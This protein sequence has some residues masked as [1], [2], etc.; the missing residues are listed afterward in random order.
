[1]QS[2]KLK[3]QSVQNNLS[4]QNNWEQLNTFRFT[5]HVKADATN[6]DLINESLNLF[7]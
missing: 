1:M 6:Q 5:H 7:N 3:A 2:T 4:E